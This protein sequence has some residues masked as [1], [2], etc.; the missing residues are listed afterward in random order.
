[1]HAQTVIR[2]LE[3]KSQIRMKHMIGPVPSIGLLKFRL[4][5]GRRLMEIVGGEVTTC[6]HLQPGTESFVG[7]GS[8]GSGVAEDDGPN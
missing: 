8:D 1:M 6:A 4:R 3:M 5:L 2:E 7:H